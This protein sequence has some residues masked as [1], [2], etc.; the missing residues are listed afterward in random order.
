MAI[1]D[2][3]TAE[4]LLEGAKTVGALW[5]AGERCQT[6]GWAVKGLENAES[7]EDQFDPDE[8]CKCG[9]KATRFCKAKVQWMLLAMAEPREI[10]T[11][12]FGFALT[13]KGSEWD[14][15]GLS[16]IWKV[17]DVGDLKIGKKGALT[18]KE[19][20]EL[21]AEPLAA[22]ATLRLIRAFPGAKVEFEKEEKAPVG[23]EKLMSGL[24]AE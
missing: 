5:R 11:G 8:L 1:T 10:A 14:A 18:M 2:K 13:M 12:E 23:T 16:L 9:V 7:C 20:K 15:S 19:L 24:S 17:A 4:R 6:T 22:T 21:M 3:P